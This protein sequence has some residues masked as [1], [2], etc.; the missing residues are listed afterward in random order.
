MSTTA[1][2][3]KIRHCSKLCGKEVFQEEIDGEILQFE[4]YKCTRLHTE[5]NCKV[6]K[7]YKKYFQKLEDDLYKLHEDLNEINRVMF[8]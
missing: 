8:H 1:R 5:H 6:F 3:S 4:D 2:R 7:E